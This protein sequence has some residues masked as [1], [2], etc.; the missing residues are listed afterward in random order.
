MS[1]VSLKPKLDR[2]VGDWLLAYKE[3]RGQVSVAG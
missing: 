3:V 2:S 1:I